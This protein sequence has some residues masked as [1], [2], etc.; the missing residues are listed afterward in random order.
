MGGS[1]RGDRLTAAHPRAREQGFQAAGVSGRTPAHS[2]PRPSE[3]PDLDRI[4][5]VL[6]EHGLE[7]L[8]EHCRLSPGTGPSGEAAAPPW[9]EPAVGPRSSGPALLRAPLPP[10]SLSFLRPPENL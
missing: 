9:A 2:C 4:I 6:L 10:P 7:H 3:V 1:K 8:P 5:P